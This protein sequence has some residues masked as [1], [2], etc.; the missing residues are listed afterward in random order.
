MKHVLSLIILVFVICCNC[1]AQIMNDDFETNQFNWNETVGKRGQAVIKD[2]V[3]HMETGK[4]RLLCTTYGPFDVSKPFVMSCDAF[5]K[6]IDDEKVFG[7]VLD[8]EDEENFMC[9]FISEGESRL[10]VI[11]NGQIVGRRYAKINLDSG[12][13]KGVKFEVEYALNEINFNVNGMKALSYRRR[14]R[15]DEFVLGTS[16]IGFFVNLGASVDFDNLIIS[17]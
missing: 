13:K 2:G 1:S 16:G 14:V 7:I 8:Y 5:V 15:N 4:E 11:K 10:L 3:L 17:Q 9:F 12:K 6:K